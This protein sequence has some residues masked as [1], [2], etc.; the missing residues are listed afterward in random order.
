MPSHQTV[1]DALSVDSEQVTEWM[2]ELDGWNIPNINPTADGTCLGDPVAAAAAADRGW[3]S[4]GGYTR[5]SGIFICFIFRVVCSNDDLDIVDCPDKL[6][7]G[8]RYAPCN[9]ILTLIRHSFI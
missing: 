2:K 7:W 6:T 9:H 1:F 3:W 4:C 5:S 8:V